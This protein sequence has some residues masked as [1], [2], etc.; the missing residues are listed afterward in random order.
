MLINSF[1]PRPPKK[2]RRRR[3][4]ETVRQRVSQDPPLIAYMSSGS[5]TSGWNSILYSLPLV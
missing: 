2:V 1:T 5:V 4:T 3:N